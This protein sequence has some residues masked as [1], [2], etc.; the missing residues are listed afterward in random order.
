MHVSHLAAYDAAERERSRRALSW[1]W[2]PHECNLL[3]VE[4]RR[5]SA[6]L[7]QRTLLFWGDSLTAQHFYSLV[8]LLGSAVVSLHDRDPSQVGASTVSGAHAAHGQQRR[9]AADAQEEEHEAEG[10]QAEVGGGLPEVELPDWC[11]IDPR[12]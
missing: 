5:L 11:E 6:W 7:G 2:A 3:P 12:P 1:T 4:G 9:Q 10:G 8:M